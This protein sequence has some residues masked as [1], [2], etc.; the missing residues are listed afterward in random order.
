MVNTCWV[1][2]CRTGYKDGQGGHIGSGLKLFNAPKNYERRMK[3]QNAIPREGAKLKETNSVCQ[4]H[5]LPEDI[6][7]KVPTISYGAYN[8]L[9]TSGRPAFSLTKTAVPSQFPSKNFKY[10]V[11]YHLI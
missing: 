2:N 7:S 8:H 5:F 10:I 1:P 9:N 11:C 6:I 3:W 4:L